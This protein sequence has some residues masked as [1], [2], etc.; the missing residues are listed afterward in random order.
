M[1]PAVIFNV[2]WYVADPAVIARPYQFAVLCVRERL[3][4]LPV[5]CCY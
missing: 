4:G 3:P 1:A 5:R 2:I